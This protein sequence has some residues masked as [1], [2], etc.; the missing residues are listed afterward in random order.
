MLKF[1]NF[2]KETLVVRSLFSL[3][4]EQSLRYS[5]MLEAQIFAFVIEWENKV[6]FQNTQQTNASLGFNYHMMGNTWVSGKS[7]ELEFWFYFLVI[8]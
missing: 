7:S 1:A 8:I 4:P 5:S 2:H 3:L 6:F